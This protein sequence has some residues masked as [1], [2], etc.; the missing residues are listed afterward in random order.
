MLFMLGQ[1]IELIFMF[2][3]AL[4]RMLMTKILEPA[5]DSLLA[6]QYETNKTNAI[7]F[8]SCEELELIDDCSDEA[9]E[10]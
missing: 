3:I 1:N 10:I 6:H 5:N 4:T 9:F 8:I 2:Q 7:P